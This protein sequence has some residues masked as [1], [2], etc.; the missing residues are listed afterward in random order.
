MSA[1]D[2]IAP[3]GSA[4]SFGQITS[5]NVLIAARLAYLERHGAGWLFRNEPP[6]A[7][8]YPRL[9]GRKVEM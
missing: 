7:P 1:R 3:A 9:R 8:G 4:S 2:V 5:G 6:P